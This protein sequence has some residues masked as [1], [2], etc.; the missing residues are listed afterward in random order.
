MSAP[1]EDT[2]RPGPSVDTEEP[3]ARGT[4]APERTDHRSAA[5]IEAD[6][7]SRL[8]RPGPT[9]RLWGWLGPLVV[10]A[11]A[12][13]LRLVDLNHPTRLMFDETYYVKQAYSLLTL[14]YE[15]EWEGEDV[16]DRFRVGDF[17]D[18]STD[19]DYVVHPQIGKWLIAI[20]LR[21]FGADNGAG[22]RFSAAIAGAATVLVLARVA[23]RLTGS[24]LLGSAA[25]LLLAVD[26]LHFTG[27]R[28]GLLDVF[29]GFFIVAALAAVLLD[30]EQSRRRLARAAA[31]DL[32]DRGDGRLSDPWGPRIG[33]RWWLVLAGVLL[34]L[35][36]G[37]KWS[38]I[39]GLA[40]LGIL[41]VVWDICARRAVGARL[42]FGA[43]VFRG[44]V[45]AFVALVPVA[46]VTYVAGWFSWFASPG[47][48]LRT[49]AA[50]EIAAQ[51][52]VD[53]SWLPN[54]L[55]SL[56]EYHLRAWDFHNGLD[57]E[58]SYEAHPAGW[59]LQLRP[60]SFY[61]EG[62]VDADCGAERCVQVISSVGNPV[63]WW[64]GL[65][66]LL[67]VLWMAVV[68]R[69]WRGWAAL[70]GYAATYLPWFAYAHRTIFTFYAIALA[71]YVTL[72]V[73]LAIAWVGGLLPPLHR[74]ARRP[75]EV[76]VDDADDDGALPTPDPD[77]T[78]RAPSAVAVRED[79]DAHGRD[80]RAGHV[81]LGAVCV[82]AVAAFV[83]F[84]PVWTGATLPYEDWHSHMWLGSWI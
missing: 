11:I 9:D 41:V 84:W 64:V 46:A 39:Y 72:V 30:R 21:L 55:N 24:T 57:S 63:V 2:E 22:W 54:P 52:A 31:A 69:D 77:G 8:L 51:G 33:V 44:G 13:V 61:W 45:P 38:A 43:G 4:D 19:A 25:G 42:W 68:R 48:Y 16:N 53:R 27:S 18:L 76:P 10:T 17:S 71:P 28:I 59:I 73:V 67:V 37:V 58:H 49:W 56:W 6:L 35:G 20:G 65:L 15:G 79:D 23:R 1:P 3:T 60:T 26:G 14:G 47:A 32:A 83:Y 5:A 34:G 66:G 75:G 40:V 74:R 80:V 70:A 7:Q 50:D 62:E 78:A 81:L 82:A 36:G 12:A 29:L